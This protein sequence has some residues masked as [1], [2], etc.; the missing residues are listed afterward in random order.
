MKNSK[1]ICLI[2]G[3]D[4]LSK[5]FFKDL[6]RDNKSSIF[7]NVNTKKD[8]SKNVFNIKIFQLK[9]IL[10]LLT[11]FK[12]KEIIFLGKISRPDLSQFKN[13]GEI[14][15]YIPILI[16]SFQK[17]DGNILSTVIQIF[18]D[19]GYRVISPNQIN[20]DYFFG[21]DDFNNQKS[22]SDLND[23]KKSVQIL[24]DLSK[25]DNAQSIVCIN[26]YI[27]AIEAA[28]GTDNLLK[29]TVSIRTKLDQINSKSGILTKIPKKNHS[30]LIDLPV[31]GPKT[32]N[33]LIKANLRGIALNSKY[34]MVYQKA[35]TL[36]LIKRYELKIYDIKK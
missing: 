14:E 34:T 13:D 12:I 23:I 24:N 7:I 8:N 16:K 31:I 26:G 36:E 2:G 32:I 28:E 5:S 27:I 4:A 15:K 35:K 25:Y 19:K 17:G 20:K 9:K 33:L 1:P 22:L 29:R 10:D 30:K 18:I 11:L 21:K 3:Y 6:K